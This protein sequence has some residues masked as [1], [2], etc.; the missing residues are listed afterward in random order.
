MMSLAMHLDMM[1]GITMGMKV[2]VFVIESIRN[3]KKKK[4]ERMSGIGL[5]IVTRNC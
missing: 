5:S 4:E 3:K 2:T 1:R